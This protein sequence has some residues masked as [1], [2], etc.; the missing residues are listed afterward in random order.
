V[1]YAAALQQ[2]GAEVVNLL[3]TSGAS[4]HASDA[5]GNTALHV[6]AAA[7]G[8][9]SPAGAATLLALLQCGARV[10]AVNRSGSTALH[11]A[12][13]NCCVD[14]AV[15]L[16]HAG[17]SPHVRDGHGR[18]ALDVALACGFADMARLLQTATVAQHNQQQQQGYSGDTTP[19]RQAPSEYPTP[20]PSPPR[21]V[22][23]DGLSTPTLGSVTPDGGASAG[24]QVHQQ[25]QQQLQQPTQS[26]QWVRFTVFAEQQQQL[27]TLVVHAQGLL[28][29]LRTTRM[30][31]DAAQAMIQKQSVELGQL[32]QV[33]RVACCVP[34][35]H[36]LLALRCVLLW[37]D[38]MRCTVLWV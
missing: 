2:Y 10:D 22:V 19:P 8:S 4:I 38:D 7:A 6:A 9:S 33:R 27:Q 5:D 1:H 31:L 21:S 20:V 13:G 18:C 14:A 30:N 16:L 17:A 35:P 34:R 24:S 3:Y 11:L 32:Q 37:C 23:H 26:P 25:A 29:T 15:V 36:S 12:S 28:S